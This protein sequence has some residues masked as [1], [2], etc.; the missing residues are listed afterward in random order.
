MAAETRRLSQKQLVA[1]MWRSTPTKKPP[2]PTWV[3]GSA[4]NVWRGSGEVGREAGF[5]ASLPAYTQFS[6]SARASTHIDQARS[7][8]SAPRELRQ[9]T[10]AWV[11]WAKLVSPTHATIVVSKKSVAVQHSAIA[12]RLFTPL[13]I[14]RSSLEACVVKGARLA[15]GQTP[16]FGKHP[17]S[18][19]LVWCVRH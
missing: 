15:T 14:R 2:N 19:G 16:C 6:S 12:K 4:K 1:S 11:M 5:A 17:K 18:D 13:R 7:T 10:R 8:S 3:P 9:W